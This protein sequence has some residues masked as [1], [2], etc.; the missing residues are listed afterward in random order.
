MGTAYAKECHT[1]IWGP[2][3]QADHTV[4]LQMD[5]LNVL[6]RFYLEERGKMRCQERAKRGEF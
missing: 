1:G 3:R 6:F 5:I 4:S 2:P